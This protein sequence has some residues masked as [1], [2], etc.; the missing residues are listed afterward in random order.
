MGGKRAA[1]VE[2]GKGDVGGGGERRCK[3]EKVAERAWAGVSDRVLGFNT[4]L[5]KSFA[6]CSNQLSFFSLKSSFR[7]LKKRFLANQELE[8]LRGVHRETKKSG[9]S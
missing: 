2:D 7:V 9:V 5:V 6:F 4:F 8:Q 3:R 1:A